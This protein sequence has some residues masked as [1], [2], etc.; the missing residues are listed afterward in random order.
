[1]QRTKTQHTFSP[2]DYG[3]E[4]DGDWY[5]FDG[6]AAAKAAQAA[7][8]KVAR[9]LRGEGFTVALSTLPNQLVR[10]GGIGSG[11]PDIELEV[12]VYMLDIVGG[13]R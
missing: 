6:K 4:W 10:R 11:H 2:L 1:M 5:T 3:F 7:R 8:T 12:S 13:L 9:Q